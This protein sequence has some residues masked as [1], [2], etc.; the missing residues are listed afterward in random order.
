MVAVPL[1]NPS[2]ARTLGIVARRGDPLSPGAVL[3]VKL[4]G[5]S[6]KKITVPAD[7]LSTKSSSKRPAK[8]KA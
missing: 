7:E 4:I 6:L 8:V 1:R 5:E 3:L 2:V